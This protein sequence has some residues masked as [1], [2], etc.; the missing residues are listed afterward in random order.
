MLA[1][2]YSLKFRSRSEKLW[3]RIPTGK[4]N[5]A[6]SLS[7]DSGKRDFWCRKVSFALELFSPTDRKID[8]HPRGKYYLTIF[9]FNGNE[10][11]ER[12]NE[13]SLSENRAD[14]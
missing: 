4:S 2:N 12:S 5:K 13:L 10:K 8:P 6:A 11:A 3:P 14:R 9:I 7:S 1:V